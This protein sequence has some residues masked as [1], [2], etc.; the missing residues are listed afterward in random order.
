MSKMAVCLPTFHN[1][2]YFR[3]NNIKIPN[4][5][6]S[7]S[8]LCPLYLIISGAKYSGVPTKEKVFWSYLINLASP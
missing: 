1:Y 8:K 4:D 5:H 6:Q 3:N 2:K 7:A